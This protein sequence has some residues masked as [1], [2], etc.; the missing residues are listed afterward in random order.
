MAKTILDNHSEKVDV[1]ITCENEWE[2]KLQKIDPRFKLVNINYSQ[3]AT[4]RIIDMVG[5]FKATLKCTVMEK[6]IHMWEAIL[7]DKT[8]YVVDEL[9]AIQIKKI[10]PHFM[11]VITV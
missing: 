1:Y 11:L 2:R 8:A 3:E 4:E 10:N 5:R 7:D 6:L 9:S